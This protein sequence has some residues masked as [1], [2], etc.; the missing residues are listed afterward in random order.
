M[1]ATDTA[2]PTLSLLVSG[3]NIFPESLPALRV[4]WL[5]STSDSIPLLAAIWQLRGPRPKMWM[6]IRLVFVGMAVE[7]IAR[8]LIGFLQ[9]SLEARFVLSTIAGDFRCLT[10]WLFLLYLLAFSNGDRPKPHSHTE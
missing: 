7:S 5:L 4:F 9:P 6:K 3:S 8:L 2:A 1:F 10:V